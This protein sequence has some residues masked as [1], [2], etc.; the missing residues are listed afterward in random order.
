MDPSNAPDCREKKPRPPLNIFLDQ[1]LQRMQKVLT[2]VKTTLKDLELAIGGS[3]IMSE[4]LQDT[5]D[6]IYDSRVPKKWLQISWDLNALGVWSA[7]LS[8][9]CLQYQEWLKQE[10]TGELNAYWLTGFF[11]PNG[12]LTA[13]KQKIT[14]TQPGWSLDKVSIITTVQKNEINSV[15][16]VKNLTNTPKRGV[17]IY[18]LFLEG[19][20]WNKNKE[21]LADPLPRQLYCQLPALAVDAQDNNAEVAAAPGNKQNQIKKYECPVYKTPFRT[22]LNYIFSVMLNTDRDEADWIL[23]GTAL[24]CQKE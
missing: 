13:V 24:L 4:H 18:G 10:K 3:I 19:A 5:L 23:K 1:E 9:R 8:K 6:A 7:D 14:R 12:F 22:G 11:N 21:M 20:S 16:E 17:L 15:E 2:T